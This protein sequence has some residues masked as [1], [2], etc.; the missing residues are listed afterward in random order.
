[1]ILT[2]RSSGRT[3]VEFVVPGAANHRTW[4]ESDALTDPGDDL[5][6]ETRPRSLPAEVTR[7]DKNI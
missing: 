2:E 3:E 1:M 5:Q 4:S 7:C 6:P